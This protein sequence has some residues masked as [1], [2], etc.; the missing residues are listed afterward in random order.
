MHKSDRKFYRLF[1][2]FVPFR[3][4]DAKWKSEEFRA[5]QK[6]K[7]HPFGCFI[8]ARVDE[9]DAYFFILITILAIMERT[10]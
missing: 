10:T 3:Q 4:S 8:L 1:I 5:W 9:K 7:K 2:S 6:P